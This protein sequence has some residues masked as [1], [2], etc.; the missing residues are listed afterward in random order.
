MV[1]DVVQAW[2]ICRSQTKA[3]FTDW[4]KQV[5][6]EEEPGPGAWLVNTQGGG[7]HYYIIR[8]PTRAQKHISKAQR[9]IAL[10]RIGRQMEVAAMHAV[11]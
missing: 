7:I 1:T 2:D 8:M 3:A 10:Q 5:G 4:D 9:V 11:T 6:T